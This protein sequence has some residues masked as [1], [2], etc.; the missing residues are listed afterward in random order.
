MAVGYHDSRPTKCPH[1]RTPAVVCLPVVHDAPRSSTPLLRMELRENVSPPCP[2]RV[3]RGD[4]KMLL[5]IRQI[6]QKA[7]GALLGPVTTRIGSETQEKSVQKEAPFVVSLTKLKPPA[8]VCSA[9]ASI[10][11]GSHLMNSSFARFERS[12]PP[13]SPSCGDAGSFPC[14]EDTNESPPTSALLALLM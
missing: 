9:N 2:L 13:P 5:P 11:S 14:S 4:G 3:L 6:L 1:P 12:T 8:P 10:V 7:Y